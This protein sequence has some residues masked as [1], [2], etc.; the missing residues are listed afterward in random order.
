MA[1]WRTCLVTVPCSWRLLELGF[2]RSHLAL[3]T[4][5]ARADKRQA[6]VPVEPATGVHAWERACIRGTGC[7]RNVHAF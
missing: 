6:V 7:R 2:R 3:Q 4:P 1:Q 5:N